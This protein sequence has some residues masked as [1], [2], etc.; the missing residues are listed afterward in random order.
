MRAVASAIGVNGPRVSPRGEA[1]ERASR[2]PFLG[3]SAALC[4][5]SA[6]LTIAWSVSMAAM[7]AMPMPGGWTMSMTWMPMPGQSR[8][9][10][11]ASFVGMWLVM[12]VAMMLPSLM[13]TLCRYRRAVARTGERRLGRLTALLGVGYFLVWAAIGL[14]VFPLGGALAA[15]E[16]RVPEL[17]RAVPTAV[18]VVVLLA[19]ALQ[20]SPWKARHLA[21]CRAAPARVCTRPA[22]PHTA[23]RHGLSAGLHC[24]YSC[25]SLMVIL[26][27]IGVMDL[28][29][30]AVVTAA[31]TIE[32]LAPAPERVA[33]AIGAGAL[34]AGALMI[35]Q[36]AGLA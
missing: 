33:R 35:A 29:A 17:A 15:V 19:G 20:L 26:L 7:D 28:R 24:S 4:A 12:M 31:I 1:S 2:G 6:A 27:V 8:L 5:A 16:M 18:G 10:G 14:A 13:P 34:G 23:W 21:R 11:A 25:G 36:A 9:A 22:D 3:V 30:M 32:R